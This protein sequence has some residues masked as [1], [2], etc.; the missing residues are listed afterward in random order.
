MLLDT[1]T[2]PPKQTCDGGRPRDR[3]AGTVIR[4]RKKQ[5][6]AVPHAA[7]E[8]DSFLLGFSMLGNDACDAPRGVRS[9]DTF[10]KLRRIPFGASASPRELRFHY[11]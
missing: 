6:T 9:N 7:I 4:A 8:S 2:P 1:Q 10:K 11:S 5:G 3:G